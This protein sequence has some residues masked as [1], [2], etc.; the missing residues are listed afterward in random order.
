V[1]TAGAGIKPTAS[2]EDPCPTMGP[3]TVPVN[4]VPS[5]SDSILDTPSANMLSPIMIVRDHTGD[6]QDAHHLRRFQNSERSPLIIL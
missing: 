2:L 6:V 4:K 3:D 5:L 1:S